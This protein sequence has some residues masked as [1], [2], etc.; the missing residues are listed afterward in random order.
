M[1]YTP[2]LDKWGKRGLLPCVD[3]HLWEKQQDGRIPDSVMAKAID[4]EDQVDR[5]MIRKTV[6]PWA[7]ALVSP[8]HRDFTPICLVPPWVADR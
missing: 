1:H 3:L 4:P 6:R 2:D 7:D 8:L 5:V